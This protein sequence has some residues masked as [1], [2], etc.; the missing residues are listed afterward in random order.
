MKYK[1]KYIY[2]TNVLKRH[3]CFLSLSLGCWHCLH[4]MSIVQKTGNKSSYYLIN[5][6]ESKKERILHS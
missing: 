6:Q 2:L 4:I 3:D 5:Q 1:N